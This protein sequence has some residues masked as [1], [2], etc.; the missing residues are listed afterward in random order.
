[1]RS[2]A[3]A[4]SMH[5][6]VFC[7]RFICTRLP[8]RLRFQLFMR[9]SDVVFGA[10]DSES[11][12][13]LHVR[14]VF[15]NCPETTHPL[16]NEIG[17]ECPYSLFASSFFRPK[18][19]AVIIVAESFMFHARTDGCDDDDPV[20]G[21]IGTLWVCCVGAC[22]RIRKREGSTY[23]SFN[24]FLNRV[25]LITSTAKPFEKQQLN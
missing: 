19:Y 2:S 11:G 6:R 14:R 13:A 21:Y 16:I 23:F 12:R 15:A 22:T 20:P 8:P 17:G 24:L 18:M 25:P 4:C 9:C 5:A 10:F 7:R 1:M 3:H